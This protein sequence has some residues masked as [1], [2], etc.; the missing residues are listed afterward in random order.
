LTNVR[1]EVTPNEEQKCRETN[2]I[3]KKQTVKKNE[4][5]I[6]TREYTYEGKRLT[7]KNSW[8]MGLQKVS[9]QTKTN[10]SA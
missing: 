6:E 3:D 2:K 10:T 5:T 9:V 7:N 1:G 8:N 4:T